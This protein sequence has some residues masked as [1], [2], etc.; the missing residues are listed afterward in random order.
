MVSM[1]RG[2]VA[3]DPG[4]SL[5]V[6]SATKKDIKISGRDSPTKKLNTPFYRCREYLNASLS[7]CRYPSPSHQKEVER[8]LTPL[9]V[10]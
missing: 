1:T 10:V 2:F 6:I 3:L 9:K 4:L 7:S 5:P 8:T